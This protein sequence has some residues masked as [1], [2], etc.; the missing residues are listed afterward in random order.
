MPKRDR[1]RENILSARR[2]CIDVHNQNIDQYKILGEHIKYRKKQNHSLGHAISG[3]V[4]WKKM[5]KSKRKKTF[6][7]Y[8]YTACSS[9]KKERRL[10]RNNNFNAWLHLNPEVVF[11]LFLIRLS[12]CLNYKQ[13]HLIF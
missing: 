8:Y 13:L 11:Y 3:M 10:H 9:S 5:L 12:R 7:Q 4:E 1:V 6:Y 2:F